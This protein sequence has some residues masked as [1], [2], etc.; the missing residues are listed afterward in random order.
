MVKITLHKIEMK[1]SRQESSGCERNTKRIQISSVKLA[2]E[3]N[4]IK[5]LKRLLD[6]GADVRAD[7]NHALICASQNARVELVSLLLKN[8]TNIHAW[9]D[10]ALKSASYKGHVEVVSLLLKNGADVHDHDDYA[11][12]LASKNGHVEVVSLLLK[13]GANVHAEDDYAEDDCALRRASKNGHVEVVSL[14]LNFG[15][16]PE[17]CPKEMLDKVKA[18]VRTILEVTQ[19]PKCL[20]DNI[21]RPMLIGY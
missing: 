2:V 19:L 12:Y 8:G 3:R 6:A 7:N 14:L 4:D 16:N 20:K 5:E 13:N 10:Y 15:A 18:D 21:I 9:D 1:R 11:L 17:K